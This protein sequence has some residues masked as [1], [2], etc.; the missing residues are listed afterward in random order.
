MTCTCN[1]PRSPNCDP[2]AEP[3]LDLRDHD[4]VAYCE[5]MKTQFP[6]EVMR[7][8]MARQRGLRA[9]AT[10]QRFTASG[11]TGRTIGPDEG[12]QRG[13]F[14]RAYQ[15]LHPELVHSGA[16]PDTDEIPNGYQQALAKRGVVQQP[17]YLAGE[18]AFGDTPP[19]GYKRALMKRQQRP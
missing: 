2:D 13:M 10:T 19:N 3:L 16:E 15:Q 18:S 11:P 6:I 1:R 12:W 8:R 17:V 4:I 5:V 9:M 7:Q 14:S